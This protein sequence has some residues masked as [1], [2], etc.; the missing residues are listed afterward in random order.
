MPYETDISYDEE[1]NT[2]SLVGN[3]T[4]VNP[5]GFRLVIDSRKYQN[6]EFTV[7]TFALPDMSAQPA[8]LNLPRRNIGLPADK[9][10]FSP[11]ELT[12]LVD[13]EFVN[14]KE[15]HEWMLGMVTE[16]DEG[17]RKSRDISLIV[18][19]SHNNMAREIKFVDAYPVSLSSLQFD[20][21]STS[22]DY[23]IASVTFQYSYYKII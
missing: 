5:T 23:L 10:E 15:I 2:G 22:V 7:Q 4:F 11:F 20:A 18:L 17:V 6:A 8:P 9:I 12:F 19:S 1:G 3:P 21:T 14:Y 13:E 16:P